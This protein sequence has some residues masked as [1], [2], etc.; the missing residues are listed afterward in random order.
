ME[1]FNALC[2][3]AGIVNERFPTR[4]IEICFGLAMS[5][6]VDEH[7]KSRH[8][9]MSFVEFLEAWA[10]CCDKASI[11]NSNEPHITVP[12]LPLAE[13][14]ENTIPLL[15]SVCSRTFKENYVYPAES[16]FSVSFADKQNLDAP[17]PQ[18]KRRMFRI[19]RTQPPVKSR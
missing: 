2:T 7:D 12:S 11:G 13:K 4:D 15:L 19:E 6:Q 9:E 18:R 10:R 3:S 5:T 16:K 14:I 1:N 8:M 17:S